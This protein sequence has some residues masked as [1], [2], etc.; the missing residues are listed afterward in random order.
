MDKILNWPS[1]YSNEDKAKV[2]ALIEA[3]DKQI[4]PYNEEWKA[5]WLLSDFTKNE[6]FV[7]SHQSK[8]VNG[9]WT[10]QKRISWEI[11]L[12]DRT[13]LTD[14]E[15][16]IM[17]DAA[18]KIIFLMRTLPK[19]GINKE[20]TLREFIYDLQTIIRWMYV[21]KQ[22]YS[23]NKLAFSMLTTQ[24][25]SE[26][27]YQFSKG[28]VPWVLDYPNQ[29]LIFLYKKVLNKSVPENLYQNIFEVPEQDKELICL[30]FEKNGFYRKKE[31]NSSVS[32]ISRPKLADLMF[33]DMRTMTSHAK[34]SVFLKQFEPS[35]VSILL[36]TQNQS[37]EFP[38]HRTKTVEEIIFDE[39]HSPYCFLQVIS[40]LLKLHKHLPNYLPEIKDMNFKRFRYLFNRETSHTPWI[41]L[42]TSLAYT[43]EALRWV[44]VYGEDLVNHYLKITKILCEKGLLNSSKSA[45]QLKKR[46][47]FVKEYPFPDSLKSLN[48]D[49]WGTKLATDKKNFSEMRSCPSLNDVL[50]VFI[51]AT[52]LIFGITKPTRESEVRNIKSDAITFVDGDGYW[53]VHDLA[54]SGTQDLRL[55]TQKPIPKISA[56]AL[57][58]VKK[59][60]SEWQLITS[61]K[62]INEN[63]YF[64]PDRDIG[65]ETRASELKVGKLNGY[66]DRFCDWVNL[67]PDSYGRRWYMREHELRKSFLITFF[68]CYKFGSL[69]AGSW[70]AGHTN[71]EHLYAYIQANF[72]GQELPNIEAQYAIQQ[73]WSYENGES[74]RTENVLDLYKSVC[75]HFEVSS[76]NLLDEKDLLDWL[77]IAF[78]KGS[79]AIEP[80]SIKD[81][82][83]YVHTRV[84]FRISTLEK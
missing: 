74:S 81:E 57:L 61:R 26:F 75:N 9:V 73:L 21:H 8:N 79:Y 18:K 39:S 59:L 58:L 13:K 69:E 56:K 83:G 35:N 63:I 54:K 2:I 70:I 77:Q 60:S 47:T 14:P 66:F 65:D 12:A 49:G 72:P 38:S 84:C 36:G 78:S 24:A 43:T 28:G 16:S 3:A 51:G 44:Q 7:K 33:W 22:I 52:L 19:G 37:R 62:I 15:N 48:I 41:P 55:N 76:I 45:N 68:W 27:L 64:L 11:K 29:L 17:L 82:L 46:E 34:F 67:P 42:E 53:V 4:L 6:W 30:W 10:H 1:T 40:G 5:S 50:S 71:S 32:L 31:A 23:P 25:F 20:T 80:Y